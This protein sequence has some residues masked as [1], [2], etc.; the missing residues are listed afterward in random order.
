MPSAPKSQ[1]P[2]TLN[3]WEC[4]RKATP[5]KTNSK[6]YYKILEVAETATSD[7][8]KKSYRKLAILHHP[9]R[10]PNNPE[11]EERFKEITEAYGVLMDTNKRRE[12]D[13]FRNNPFTGR[14]S[15]AG[16]SYSQQE[17]FENMFRQG[18]GK[19][20]LNDLNKE[21]QR[22][23]YRSG[24]DFFQGILFTGAAGNLLRLLRMI[25]GPIGRIGTGLWVLQSVGTK[26]YQFNQGRQKQSRGG[27]SSI[28]F[29]KPA[30]LFGKVK[31]IFDKP[32]SQRDNSLN[33]YFRLSIPSADAKS[34]GQKTLSFQTGNDT[35][36]LLVNI[37]AGIAS[38]QKL[39]I[40]EKG[41]K[42]S[43]KRGDVI[44]TID[45][46]A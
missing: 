28:P 38:G 46:V 12:Y 32:Q 9:D 33:L 14:G 27:S 11:A 19:D 13:Q 5:M 15:G 2:N 21:F 1:K 23:G 45:V 22:T 42:D 26:L 3:N 39:R 24:I 7:E 37:P 18:F 6:D 41:L 35:E 10:N 31:G 29:K 4:D 40:R 20:I 36:N 17:I 8:I 43:G 16:F 25:P 44:L 34:G 30:S